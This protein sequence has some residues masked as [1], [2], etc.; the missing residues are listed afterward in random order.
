MICHLVSYLKVRQRYRTALQE[1]MSL[2]DRELADIGITRSHITRNI[3]RSK[4]N[5]AST[6][7][8]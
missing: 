5:P 3:H 4:F 6:L 2:S 1:L 7:W 8:P